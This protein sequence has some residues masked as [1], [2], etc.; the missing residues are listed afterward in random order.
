MT[1]FTCDGR[2]RRAAA[3]DA[4]VS[5]SYASLAEPETRSRRRTRTALANCFDR[6]PSFDVGQLLPLLPEG[7]GPRLG[8]QCGSS[9]VSAGRGGGEQA[10]VRS[11]GVEPAR[12][13]GSAG[14]CGSPTRSADAFDQV[15]ERLG[16]PVGDLGLVGARIWSRPEEQRAGE[17]ADLDRHRGVGHVAGELVE[18]SNDCAKASP[19]APRR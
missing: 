17:R 7:I 11:A 12:H 2:H 13:A 14:S 19:P 8:S 15:V 3:L 16:G 6:R 18:G 10:S 1:V 4:W 9:G 5:E